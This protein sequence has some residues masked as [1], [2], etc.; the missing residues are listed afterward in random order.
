MAEAHQICAAGEIEALQEFIMRNG[1][2]VLRSIDGE[3]K[4]LFFVACENGHLD[5]ARW[6]HTV[7]I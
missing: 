5:L 2:A 7:G 6:L 3:E 1:D 4:T